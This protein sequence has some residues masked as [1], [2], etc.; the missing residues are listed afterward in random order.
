MKQLIHGGI[1]NRQYRKNSLLYP[2]R[3]R[4][5]DD[6]FSNRREVA[7]VEFQGSSRNL[8]E[9]RAYEISSDADDDEGS[10]DNGEVSSGFKGGN[11]EQRFINLQHEWNSMKKSI[12]QWF[13]KARNSPRIPIFNPSPQ[14]GVED[15]TGGRKNASRFQGRR[16]FEDSELDNEESGRSS[17]SSSVSDGDAIK[18]GVSSGSNI[19]HKIGACGITEFVRGMRRLWRVL[20]A[21]TCVIMFGLGFVLS[22]NNIASNDYENCIIDHSDTDNILMLIFDP[23][24]WDALDSKMIDILAVKGPKRDIFKKDYVKGGLINEGSEDWFH[25][26]TRLQEHEYELHCR[27]NA[28]KTIDHVAQNQLKKE[29]NHWKN[30]LL[31][32]IS[33]VKFL[34]KHSIAFRGTKERLYENNNGKFLGLIEM[35]AEFDPVI[36]EHVRRITSDDIHFY[37]LDH[38]IQNE[39]ISLIASSIKAEIIKKV[40]QIKYFSIILDCTPDVSHQ[41]QMSI[42]LKNVDISSSSIVI[43]E[44]FLDFMNVSDTTW[45]RLFDVLLRELKFVGHDVDNV[46]GQGYYDNVSNMKGKHQGVSKKLLDINP[47]AFY[48]SCGS[49]SLNLMLFDMVNTC[50]K[51]RDFF[52]VIQQIYTIF[53]NSTKRCQIQKYNIKEL[54]LKSLSSTR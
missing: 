50:G 54:I 28:N 17:Y 37:Y 42:I 53:A 38:N 1:S 49:H 51:V 35:L 32:I 14:L 15:W 4:L 39:L 43:E 30:V 22:V 21:A 24:Y 48:T 27:L 29:R 33:I 9:S 6:G 19:S 36:Q 7:T 16:L 44:S 2:R 5:G 40:K 45:Q 52:G 12:P 3:R 13:S 25:I 10:E 46:Q 8:Y 26:G 41:E 34:A 47:R 20:M 23:S 31:S 11:L 18:V